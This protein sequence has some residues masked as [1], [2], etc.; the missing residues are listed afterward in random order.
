MSWNKDE[1]VAY[2]SSLPYFFLLS[3]YE[4]V[5]EAILSYNFFQNSSAL[6]RK[7]LIKLFSKKTTSL[8]KLT[9]AKESLSQNI[10]SS[11]V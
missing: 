3:M 10:Y 5:G 6:L 8:L 2:A 1:K 9:C 4:V 7:L 11:I